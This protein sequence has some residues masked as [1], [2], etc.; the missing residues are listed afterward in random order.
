MLEAA[1]VVS[2]LGWVRAQHSNCHFLH[3]TYPLT[4]ILS[5]QFFRLSP[6]NGQYCYLLVLQWMPTSEGQWDS[7]YN[8][9]SRECFASAV[10]LGSEWSSIFS[11][12]YSTRKDK[13]AQAQHQDTLI[14]SILK[15]TSNDTKQWIVV[16][17]YLTCCF[18]FQD[19]ASSQEKSQLQLTGMVWRVAWLL[20]FDVDQFMTPL[21][22][23]AYT[24]LHSFP[25]TVGYKPRGK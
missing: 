12:S 5:L 25:E 10:L 22:K 20:E 11:N 6:N 17:C 8:S 2:E 3:Q 23:R 14:E 7:S 24:C 18:T 1:Q 13:S 9:W 16:M 15:S 21:P 4:S 19:C